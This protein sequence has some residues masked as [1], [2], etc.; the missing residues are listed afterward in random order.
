[1]DNYET[2]YNK[3][4]QIYL[5]E[6]GETD[7][8][9]QIKDIDVIKVN[10][11][12]PDQ[13][14]NLPLNYIDIINGFSNQIN[15]KINKKEC[16]FYPNNIKKEDDVMIRIKDSESIKFQGLED[17]CEIVI[18]QLEQKFYHCYLHADKVYFYRSVVTKNKEISSYLPH[19]D[20]H[21]IQLSK[22]M[23]YLTDVAEDTGPF[24]Y[25][26]DPNDKPVFINPSRTGIDHWGSH[27]WPGSRVP[28]K[29]LDEYY[30]NGYKW[31]K[32]IGKKGTMILFTENH[33]HK[34]TVSEKSH[35]DVFILQVR[36]IKFKY[37]PY[38]SPNKT[39]SFE[40]NDLSKDPD[41]NVPFNK[42]FTK[43]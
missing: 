1:M 38:I 11:T 29:V 21:P 22:V 19:V 39:G 42:N 25:L 2:H 10:Y 12:K 7:Q 37:R 15:E 35:R 41:D 34:A 27:K 4:K 36:P 31:K 16:C 6:F 13:A 30:K 20:N 17:L 5:K 33:I 24:Q 26:V 40:M 14:I 28:S 8:G 32:V 3:S 9:L 23:I 18:P 43:K